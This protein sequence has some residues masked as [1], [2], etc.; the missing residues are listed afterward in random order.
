MSERD[1]R[2]AHEERIRS[3]FDRLAP[4]YARFKGR[5]RYYHDFLARWC[6][7]LLPP[8]SSV[9]GARFLRMRPTISMP[10]MP[11]PI[12]MRTVPIE[13]KPRL[14]TTVFVCATGAAAAA[15]PE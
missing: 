2:A 8:G 7:S 13:D 4:D 15:D 5:N 3:H 10:K 9:T 11:A 14:C 6:R 12:A 1:A